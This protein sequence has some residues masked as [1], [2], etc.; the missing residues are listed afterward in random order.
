MYKV[1][2]SQEIVGVSVAPQ[3]LYKMEATRTKTS[4]FA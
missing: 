3:V 2:G 1:E 4:S